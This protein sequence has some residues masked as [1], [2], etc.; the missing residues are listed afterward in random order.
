M[1]AKPLTADEA[2]IKID[3]P[4]NGS[5]KI[6]EASTPEEGTAQTK[7]VKGE[8]HFPNTQSP[9]SS[10]AGEDVEPFHWNAGPIEIQGSVVLSTLALHLELAFNEGDAGYR[11]IGAFDADLQ[12]SEGLHVEYAGSTTR[13]RVDVSVRDGKYVLVDAARDQWSKKRVLMTLDEGRMEAKV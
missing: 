8:T 4:S 1:S 5:Y 11:V 7:A 13:A 12:Q 9:S 2:Y 3:R 10:S 6:T